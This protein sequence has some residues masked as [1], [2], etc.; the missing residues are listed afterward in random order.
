MEAAL[1]CGLALL[2][3]AGAV[4]FAGDDAGRQASRGGRGG[5]RA[6]TA[7]S[8]SMAPRTASGRLYAVDLHA[9]HPPPRWP[10]PRC[11]ADAA[12]AAALTPILR[13]RTGSVAVGIFDQA[14]GVTASYGGRT[15]FHTASIVK[16]DILAALLLDSQR[17]HAALGQYDRDLATEMIE[18]SDNDAASTLWDTIG[19]G[20]GIAAADHDLGLRDTVPDPEGYWGL[21]STTVTDQLRLL[22]V[23][24]SPRSPLTPAS[25]RFEL[26]LLRHVDP[27]QAWGVTAAADPGTRPAVKNGWLPASPQGWW[28]I[29]SIGVISHA[30]H[31][32][33]AAVLSS[34]QPSPGVGIAQVEALAKAAA[35]AVTAL[36]GA[37]HRDH[38]HAQACT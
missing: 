21:T 27:G 23:L 26:S 7:I 34:G 5:S 30:G 18:S 6:A 32:L 15:A 9:V 38:P 25:R 11:L 2:C 35:A 28:M 13:H 12:L 16:V 24:T 33:L 10:P 31:R 1:A 19:G 36:P 29:N 22:A 4:L 3:V 20:P 37:R 14:T 8:P 17:R